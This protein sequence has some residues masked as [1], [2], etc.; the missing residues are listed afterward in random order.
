MSAAEVDDVEYFVNF[1]SPT[2]R[3]EQDQLDKLDSLLDGKEYA[4]LLV[5]WLD[6]KDQ[7]LEKYSKFYEDKGYDIFIC[8]LICRTVYLSYTL[9][10]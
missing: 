6:C 2:V 9:V 1:P 5:G 3:S 4:V 10:L 7:Y 8:G